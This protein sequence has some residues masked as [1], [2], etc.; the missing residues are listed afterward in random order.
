MAGYFC[1][2]EIRWKM[3][4]HRNIPVHVIVT[5]A[6]CFHIFLLV[7]YHE[8]PSHLRVKERRK[9]AHGLTDLRFAIVKAHVIGA[10]DDVHVLV[11][12]GGACH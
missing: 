6:D 3:N 1:L 11:A 8:V 7:S 12:T 9:Y 4:I 5:E 10:F 2:V